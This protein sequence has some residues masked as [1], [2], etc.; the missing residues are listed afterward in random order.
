MQIPIVSRALTSIREVYSPDDY[1]LLQVVAEMGETDA[2][3]RLAAGTY[4]FFQMYTGSLGYWSY[5]WNTPFMGLQNLSPLLDF[6]SAFGWPELEAELRS[7]TVALQRYSP[8]QLEAYGAFTLDGP[9]HEEI[10]AITFPEAITQMIVNDAADGQFPMFRKA[11]L[12]L[13]PLVEF[14]EFADGAELRAW[15]A[16]QG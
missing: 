16:A 9:T 11:T 15:R 2:N 7:I 10:N 14:I 6:V 3:D 5:E 8:E 1:G 13:E 12:H 4:A